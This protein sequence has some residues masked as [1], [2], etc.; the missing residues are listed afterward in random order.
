MDLFS[1]AP[2]A[3]NSNADG[4]LEKV[5]TQLQ[6]LTEQVKTIKDSL[7]PSN[8]DTIFKSQSAEVLPPAQAADVLPPAVSPA[9]EAQGLSNQALQQD[10]NKKYYDGLGGRVSLSL[11]R[12]EMLV[13]NNI[14]KNTNKNWSQILSQLETATTQQQV[15]DI[16]N[17]SKL[18]FS[19]NSIGGTRKKRRSG[20]KRRTSKRH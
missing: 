4:K 14:G 13:K 20:K 16:I 19:A 1:K 12:I 15:Q 2:S 11:P 5:I 8:I 6:G 10:K 17:N 9:A 7:S 3:D 18:S